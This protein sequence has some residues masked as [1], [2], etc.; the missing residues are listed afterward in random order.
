MASDMIF[1]DEMW[2]QSNSTEPNV[3]NPKIDECCGEWDK[4]G[5]CACLD[6]DK[7]STK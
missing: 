4:L 2:N 5:R 7:V 1:W 6:K 3:E